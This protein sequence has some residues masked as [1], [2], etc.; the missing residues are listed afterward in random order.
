MN[1]YYKQYLKYIKNTGGN[2]TQPNFVYDWEPIGEQVW[3]DLLSQGLVKIVNNKIFLTK[4]GEKELGID[5]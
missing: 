2:A 4:L 1:T 5:E 3:T